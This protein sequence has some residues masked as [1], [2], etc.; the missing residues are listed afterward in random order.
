MGCFGCGQSGHRLRD[1]PSKQVQE[2]GN[3]RAQSKT[4]V[5]PVCYPTQQGNSSGRGGD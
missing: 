2:G 5:A 1:G 3:G 4:S